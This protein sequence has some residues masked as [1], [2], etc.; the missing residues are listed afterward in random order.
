MLNAELRTVEDAFSL[1][2]S[3]RAGILARETWR[4]AAPYRLPLRVRLRPVRGR[5]AMT[6]ERRAKLFFALATTAIVLACTVLFVLEL[7]PRDELW[8]PVCHTAAFALLCACGFIAVGISSG[9]FVR[10][11]IA[12]AISDR[13]A[14][15]A[16]ALLREAEKPLDTSEFLLGAASLGELQM[17]EYLLDTGGNVH[18]TDGAWGCATA[19]HIAAGAGNVELA[20]LLLTRGAD[21]N[22][23]DD[24]GCVP[25]H[26]A[27]GAGHREMVELLLRQGAETEI[28][29]LPGTPA[30]V[31]ERN[32]C[33]DIAALLRERAVREPRDVEP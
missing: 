11:A 2:F 8:G 16:L 30:E 10:R 3:S 1:S 17:V 33:A 29:G 23:P 24:H 22:R 28:A 7:F 19:L 6:R 21:V 13:D 31:A 4:S 12:R 32:G 9:Y 20:K 15:Q 14:E 27:A 5:R 26:E 18:A 25:L